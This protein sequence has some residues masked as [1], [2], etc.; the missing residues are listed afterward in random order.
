MANVVTWLEIPAID[1]DRAIKFYSTILDAPIQKIDRG[2]SFYAYLPN[3]EDGVGGALAQGENF[4]PSTNGTT[5]YLNAG[6][7]L[8][9]ILARV[10]DA[11]GKITTP[12]T[13]IGEDGFI[14][15]LIDT[16]GNKIGLHSRS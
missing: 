1:I 6:D 16:E 15:M 10:E 5:V 12:R 2:D 14:A 13:S 3:G 9:P 4:V 7:D 8:N 11:G